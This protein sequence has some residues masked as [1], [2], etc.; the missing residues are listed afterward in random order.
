VLFFAFFTLFLLRGLHLT[1]QPV[2]NY[3]KDVS[4]P[5]P[6]AAALGKFGDYS[7]GNFTG[8]PDISIPIYTVQEGPLSLPIG[9]SYHA[10]GIKV[11][12]MAS[13]VG[14]GWALNAGGIISRTVQGI[15]DEGVGG[16]YNNATLLETRINQ[17]NSTTPALAAAAA[18]E[19]LNS[20]ITSGLID[21]EPDL[22]SFNVGGYSG[23]FY[24][25]KNQKAQFIPKQDLIL[26][27]DG[28]FEGFPLAPSLPTKPYQTTHH[29]QERAVLVRFFKTDTYYSYGVSDARQLH[30]SI[31]R[32]H[33]SNRLN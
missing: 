24:I 26:E 29:N 13:W 17:A 7:V 33:R 8:V 15:K 10:S 30:F 27:V 28:Q 11:G 12:E 25:D 9:I 20:D 2:N 18:N 4:M 3:S 31:Y 1:A 21:G 32:L 19:Q 6:N 22:F 16:Y 5:A 14:A 23:K